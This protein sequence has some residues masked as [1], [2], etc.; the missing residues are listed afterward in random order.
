MTRIAAIF[1]GQGS[2]YPGMAKGLKD[3][4]P[5][6]KAIYE[7]ASDAVKQDLLNLCLE[8]NT[9]TLQ[10]TRNAQPCILVTSLAW[11]HVLKRELDFRP[12]AFA[13][14]SLGEYSALVAAGAL[15]LSEA[16]PLVQT[17]GELMQNAVPVG[18][19]KMAAVLGL[20]D[21]KVEALCSA[22]SRGNDSLVAPR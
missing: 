2:Q 9:E 17:R 16:A 18:K 7:E 11:F 10:L 1:P 20:E 13:G 22:A 3:S 5:W 4:F 21:E 8:G 6:T 14:H 19:G 15:S 12:F